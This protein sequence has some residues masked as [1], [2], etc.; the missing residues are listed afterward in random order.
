MAQFPV[1]M[2]GS[3]YWSGLLDWIK[4]VMLAEGAISPEDLN[5]YYLTDD[6]LEVVDIV[7]KAKGIKWGEPIGMVKRKNNIKK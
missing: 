1:I 4:D 5:L 2:M 6:P 7:R 3:K